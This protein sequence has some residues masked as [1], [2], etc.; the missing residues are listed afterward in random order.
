MALLAE[1]IRTAFEI[2]RVVSGR[3]QFLL[4][5]GRCHD[6]LALAFIEGFGLMIGDTFCIACVG[7][8]VFGQEEPE[9]TVIEARSLCLACGRAS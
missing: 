5:F 8:V 3:R 1:N 7:I 4:I 9:G 6:C 2:L